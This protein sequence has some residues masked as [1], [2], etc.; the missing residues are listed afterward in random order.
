[1]GGQ[2]GLTIR[3]ADGTEHRM[4]RWTNILPPN[5]RTNEFYEGEYVWKE[6]V[7]H[8]YDE[9]A[10]GEDGET[11]ITS[12]GMKDF[13]YLAP[14]EYGIVV[15]DYKTMTLV[16]CQSYMNFTSLMD[17]GPYWEHMDRHR[18][19]VLREFNPPLRSK[20]KG[21]LKRKPKRD[22]TKLIEID[23]DAWD[24]Y[25]V[26]YSSNYMARARDKVK[27]LGFKL[28]EK[29]EELWDAWIADHKL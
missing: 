1:M 18:G 23:Q 4:E 20:M 28:S 24:M 8:W 29:E 25:V 5:V 14:S 9:V 10:K 13:S 6:I 17:F 19:K 3:E 21:L 7:Q 22:P 26:P 2:I 16:S 27:E 11:L 15:I 12:W